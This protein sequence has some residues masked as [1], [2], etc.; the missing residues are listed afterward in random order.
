MFKFKVYRIDDIDVQEYENTYSNKNFFCTVDWLRFL[1]EFRKVTPIIIRIMNEKDELVG[2]FTGATFSKF[3]VKFFGSPFYGWMGLHMGFD[4][5][6]LSHEKFGIVLE[7][8]IDFIEKEL[9]VKFFILAD[10]KY[11]RESL[12]LCKKKLFV[13]TDAWSYFL[14]IGKSEEEI[15]KKF[16]SGYRTCIRKFEKLGGTIVE[17]YSENFIIEHNKQLVDVFE[18]KSLSAPDYSKRMRLLSTKYR[19]RVLFIK[20]LDEK[21][22]N[23]ASSYYLGGGDMAFFASNASYTDALKYNANQALM[24]YAIKYWKNKGIKTLDLAGRGD[25]KANFG[26]ELKSTPIIVWAKHKWQYNLIQGFRSIYYLRFRIMHK[27]KD[28]FSGKEK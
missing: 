20:A 10:F 2:H 18:R 7:E 9:N 25:Y 6:N 27:I 24:W 14:D 13:E 23:I 22:N 5:I 17:D 21:G 8:I 3:G 19:D 4:F 1:S 15:F 28:I 11:S 12:S 16:K 26:S